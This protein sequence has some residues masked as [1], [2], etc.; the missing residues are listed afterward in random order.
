MSRLWDT[1]PELIPFATPEELETI[2][3]GLFVV[4]EP[5]VEGLRQRLDKWRAQVPKP[6]REQILQVTHEENRMHARLNGGNQQFW[7][8]LEADWR[9]KQKPDLEPVRSDDSWPDDM[10]SWLEAERKEGRIYKDRDEADSTFTRTSTPSDPSTPEPPSTGGTKVPG[11]LPDESPT[12][13]EKRSRELLKFM[14]PQLRA[15]WKKADFEEKVAI[16]ETN[17]RLYEEAEQRKKDRIVREQDRKK[18]VFGLLQEFKEDPSRS[19][20]LPSDD[21]TLD[22]LHTWYDEMLKPD[23]KVPFPDTPPVFDY[24]PEDERLG[25][26]MRRNLASTSQR[27]NVLLRFQKSPSRLR[28]ATKPNLLMTARLRGQF[29]FKEELYS[30]RLV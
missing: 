6:T 7:D 16:W 20:L 4:H 10:R 9:R 23:R 30:W 22:E 17:E 11:Q 8:G 15:E 2:K 19:D 14:P 12:P 13:E 1:E 26:V 3:N 28:L 5:M 21:A 29:G 25:T 27:R 18:K 24:V